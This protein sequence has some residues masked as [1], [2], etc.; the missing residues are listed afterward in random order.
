MKKNIIKS[1][2]IYENEPIIGIYLGKQYSYVSIIKNGK[3][4]II[5]DKLTEERRIP[6]LVYFK[7]KGEILI[8]SSAKNNMFE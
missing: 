7:E 8:G 5:E 3:V 4:K 1:L 6:S 2:S